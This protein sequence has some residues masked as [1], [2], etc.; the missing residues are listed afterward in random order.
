MTRI[1]GIII[2]VAWDAH[3]NVAE[4]GIE[5]FGE[6]L[7]LIDPTFG[8]SRIKLL[9]RQ[10]VEVSGRIVEATG[11]KTIRVDHITPL[12]NNGTHRSLDFESNSVTIP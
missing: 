9:L 6:E 11:K 10:A 5:T 1:Q 12:K 7:F 4:V 8:I 3:G 2:P